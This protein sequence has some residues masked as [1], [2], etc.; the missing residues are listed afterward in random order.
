VKSSLGLVLLLAGSG[1]VA[2]DFAVYDG[3]LRAGF[4]HQDKSEFA[5]GGKLHFE[6]NPINCVNFGASFYTTQGVDK[7]YNSGVGFFSSS[8][9]SYS[10]LGEAYIKAMIQNTEIKLGRQE[11]DTPYADTDDIGMV[12]NTFEALTFSN[13]SLKDTTI[14]AGYL[15][16][17]S[18]VDAQ[19][20]EKFTS[21]GDVYS[22][23]VSYEGF[24]DVALSAWYYDV[25]RLAK[26]SYLE[27]SIEKKF[28]DLNFDF[29]FQY[30]NQ[31]FKSA[32][33]V[34]V[35]G[36]SFGIGK[37]GITLSVAYDKADST[38]GQAADNF[39]GGGPFF[40]N[41]EH[42]TMAEVGANGEGIRYGL[43]FDI[44]EYGV[45][46]LGVGM[47]YLDAK[48]DES[49]INEVDF[50]VNYE[51]DDNLRLDLIYSDA[52]DNL[53]SSESFKNTRVFVNYS[54]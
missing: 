42:D 45:S 29:D 26:M 34:D 41:C 33:E 43:E 3:Y 49:D 47:S 25:D 17:M 19:I 39:F 28:A 31:E 14:F 46:G 48:G 6:T 12:P 2:D 36:A 52:T 30:T 53:D 32:G 44:S 9:H 54:F 27:A 50:V 24:E 11:I 23:G 40:I 21:I 35:Y 51:V 37:N 7:K 16:K 1:L 15:K 4:Q 18:G 22:V 13:S 20:P 8:K 10:I 38:D 5:V